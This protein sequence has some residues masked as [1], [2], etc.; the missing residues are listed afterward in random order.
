ML[1][2]RTL[3]SENH[4]FDSEIQDFIMHKVVLPY[5]RYSWTKTPTSTFDD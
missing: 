2:M 4:A 5:Q 3:G 1:Q